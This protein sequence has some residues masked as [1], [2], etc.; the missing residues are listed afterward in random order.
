MSK[1]IPEALRDQQRSLRASQ[2][3]NLLEEMLGQ[4]LDQGIFIF[5]FK[6]A[7]P[8]IPL[9]RLTEASG[10]SRLCVGGFDDN[11]LDRMLAPWL[12]STPLPDDG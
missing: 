2:L 12:G 9:R 6:E 7:F 4:P 5:K 8:E 11:D 1:T 10:W 3:A